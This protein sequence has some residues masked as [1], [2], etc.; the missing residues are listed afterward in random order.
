[1]SK[2]Y[3]VIPLHTHISV[4]IM[5]FG[6]MN[7][8]YNQDLLFKPSNTYTELTVYAYIVNHIMTEVLV[9]NKS[10]NTMVLP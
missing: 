8:P 9:Y 7:L 10:E 5:D 2:K 1:M 4:P 6:N 3:T